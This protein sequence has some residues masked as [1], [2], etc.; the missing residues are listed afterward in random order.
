MKISALKEIIELKI[1]NKKGTAKE[2]K[3]LEFYRHLWA[4]ILWSRE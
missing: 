1:A 2:V 4:E 3:L